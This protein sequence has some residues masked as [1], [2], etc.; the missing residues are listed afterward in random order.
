MTETDK[1]APVKPDAALVAK[2]QELTE[3]NK[4][5]TL[6]A[7]EAVRDRDE[8]LQAKQSAVSQLA[9]LEEAVSRNNDMVENLRAQRSL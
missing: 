7:E 8:A 6:I 5:L 9:G 2:V 4:Q 3:T 1:A